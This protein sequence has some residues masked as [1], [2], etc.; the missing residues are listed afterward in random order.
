VEAVVHH[1]LR[2]SILAFLPLGLAGRLAAQQPPDSL[3]E[4]LRRAEEAIDRLQAQ[5]GEQARAAVRSHSRNRV[6]VSGL[7]LLNGFYNSGKTNNSDIPQYADTLVP[8]DTLGLPNGNAGGTVRQTRLGLTVS[9]ARALGAVVTGSLQVDFLGGQQASTGGRTYPLPRI[10]TASVRLDWAH[11]GLLVGQDALVIAPLNPVSFAAFAPPLF[12]ASG[13]LW[14]RLPQA[15]LTVETP[16]SAHL[17]VQVAA[18][19]PMLPKA[20][21][22][23]LTQPDSAERSRRPSGEGRV[24]LAWGS[25]ETSSEVGFGAHLGWIATTGDTL[26]RSYAIAGDVSLALGSHVTLAGEAFTGQAVAG[27]GGG[28]VFQELGIGGVPVRATGGWAQLDVRP[29]RAWSLGGGYGTDR[30]NARDLPDGA[31]LRN[32]VYA[33]HLIWRPGGG[34]MFGM[35]WRRTETTYHRGTLAVHHVNVYAG[36]AF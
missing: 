13:N 3:A 10:R 5:L 32:V 19:A 6:E 29:G 26:L 31:R 9:D 4:R 33:G 21:G 7:I 15:R 22:E 24:Y 34:L 35:E 14:F 12:A 16:G 25:G 28:A 27:F 23:V 18:L 1:L 11:V 2:A 8:A 36:L 17:G 30:P 20:Q